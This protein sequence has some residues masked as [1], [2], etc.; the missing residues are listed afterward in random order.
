MRWTFVRNDEMKMLNQS[1]N[2]RPNELWVSLS[3]KSINIVKTSE[4]QI[5]QGG[6]WYQRPR[7]RYSRNGSPE[8]LYPAYWPW[9]LL[10]CY[11]VVVFMFCYVN[12]VKSHRE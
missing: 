6:M 9:H 3:F 11:V 12:N 7:T 8:D 1:I 5:A 10:L 2:N 4:L